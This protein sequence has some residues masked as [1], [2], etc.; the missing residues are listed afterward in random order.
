MTALKAALA[1]VESQKAGK[2]RTAVRALR[3]APDVIDVMAV[4]VSDVVLARAAA[5]VSGQPATAGFLPA[6]GEASCN[7][8]NPL[9]TATPVRRK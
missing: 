8:A 6:P 7:F 4:P 9:R 1:L 2:P 5:V 3:P